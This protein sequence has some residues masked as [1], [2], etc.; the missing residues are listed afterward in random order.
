MVF[1]FLV[2]LRLDG[3]LG[4]WTG[5]LNKRRLLLWDDMALKRGTP[6]LL[7]P[8]LYHDT[9]MELAQTSPNGRGTSLTPLPHPRLSN[10]DNLQHTPLPTP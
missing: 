2:L 1:G 3:E 4:R 10:Y 9:C 6:E 7:I 8:H 5:D